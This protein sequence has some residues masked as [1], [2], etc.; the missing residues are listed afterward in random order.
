MS[1]NLITQAELSAID[2]AALYSVIATHSAEL[3]KLPRKARDA[4]ANHY[5]FSD[6][7][8]WTVVGVRALDELHLFYNSYYWYLVFKKE[9]ENSNG[10]DAG[11]EQYSFKLLEMAPL[12]VDWTVVEKVAILAGEPAP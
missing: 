7:N 3:E 11:I 12:D 6:P 1:V 8:V 9:C 2:H 10:F 4:L 5:L